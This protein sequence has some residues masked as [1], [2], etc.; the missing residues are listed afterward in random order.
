MSAD[1][2]RYWTPTQA[3]FEA[4]ARISGDDNPIH[5]DPVF[6]AR[7]GFGRTVAHGMLIYSKIWDIL[8]TLAPG[9]LRAQAMMFPNPAYAGERLKLVVRTTGP[10]EFSLMATRA[11]DGAVV[12][13]GS[14][15]LEARA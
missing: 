15:T 5:V 2:V 11:A 9:A 6:A 1:L 8:Q 12:F 3:E 14:A 4:F 10:G 13:E 7:S